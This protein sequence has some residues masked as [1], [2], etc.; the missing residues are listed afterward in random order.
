MPP[1][2]RAATAAQLVTNKL[3]S[4]TLELKGHSEPMKVWV[5]RIATEIH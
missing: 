1:T 4:R 2:L 3:E 5:E